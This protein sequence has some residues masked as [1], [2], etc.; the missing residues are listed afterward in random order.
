MTNGT[1]VVIS[2]AALTA[3]CAGAL[4][5]GQ[6]RLGIVKPQQ[7]SIGVVDEFPD[8]HPAEAVSAAVFEQINRDRGAAGVAPVRWDP[9][10][11]ALAEEYTR[12]QIRE[13]AIGHFLLDGVPPYARLS[14]KGDLGVGSENSSAYIVSGGPIDDA[15]LALALNAQKDMLEEKPP[16]DGHRKAILDPKAS[17]V[18]VGWSLAGGNFR[19]VEEFTARRFDWLHVVQLGHHGSAIRVKGHALPGMSIAF[20]S[21]ARQPIPSALSLE[22]VNSRH[23]YSYPNPHYALV[24]AGSRTIAIGLISQRCLTPS[25]NGRFSFNYQLDEP[26]LWTFIL[27]FDRKGEPQPAPGGSFTV[28]V[29]EETALSVRS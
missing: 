23:S 3:A 2:A 14:R 12:A 19:M 29:E 5:P 18:G 27:Y 15:P 13:G 20:V 9:K 4:L 11:A 21:V 7:F 17:H 22:E 16:S 8:G 1:V 6:R 28:W 24:P 10:A 25:F 26:G